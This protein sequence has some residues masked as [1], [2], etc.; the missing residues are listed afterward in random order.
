MY[1]R[2]A[3]DLPGLPER[4]FK[5]GDYI[6][7]MAFDL[8]LILVFIVL[9]GVFVFIP[10]LNMTIFRPIL[11][12]FIILFVPGYSFIAALFPARSGINSIERGV[13]SFIFSIVVTALFGFALNYTP[14][15]IRLEPIAACLSIFIVIC[16]LIANKKRHDLP[17]DERFALDISI[18]YNSV[19]HIIS[20]EAYQNGGG[21]TNKALN[22]LIVIALLVSMGA[23]TYAIIL[24]KQG[25]T[26]TEFYVLG[27]DG[28]AGH[29]P[30][31]M[32]LGNESQVIV[33]TVNHEHR[34]VTYDLVVSLNGTDRN[35]WINTESFTLDDNQTMEKK[36]DI[37]PDTVGAN[38]KIQF[39]LYADG[40][41]SAPYKE[42]HIW[43][44][45]TQPRNSSVQMNAPVN[46]TA[47]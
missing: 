23:I 38:V 18:L 12:L 17:E 30:V 3:D 15:G 28:V 11:G 31:N 22:V 46:M 41:F 25:E 42:L 19:A 5:P 7:G 37:V 32:A 26:F 16:V 47:S 33:G 13:L 44:N 36:V 8:K 34:T 10:G 2:N 35:K 40:N 43:V 14:L 45:V 39:L 6:Q 21:F 29:Y 1:N 24:P 20:P 27:A 4:S 9:M